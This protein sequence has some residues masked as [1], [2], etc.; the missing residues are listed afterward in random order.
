MYT[1]CGVGHKQRSDPQF[2]GLWASWVEED[3]H[4]CSH[5]HPL[6]MDAANEDRLLQA[7][8]DFPQYSSDWALIRFV[9]STSIIP[10]VWIRIFSLWLLTHITTRLWGATSCTSVSS[11]T[12]PPN[13]HFPTLEAARDLIWSVW[14]FFFC[15]QTHTGTHS[16]Y[17]F[18]HKYSFLLNFAILEKSSTCQALKWLDYLTCTLCL[19]TGIHW[20]FTLKLV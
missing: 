14:A 12:E 19:F 15:H 7:Q 20:H 10:A 11:A 16:K 8:R 13:D 1:T 2:R 9:G 18:L 17:C 3:A 5:P 4:S 6:Y